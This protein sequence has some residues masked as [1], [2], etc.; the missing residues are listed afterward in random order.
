EE[1]VPPVYVKTWFHTGFFKNRT[2]ISKQFA[3][4]YFNGDSQAWLLPDTILPEGL[5]AIEAREACRALRG[6]ALRK[7][8]YAQDGTA[9]ESIPYTIEEK[10]FD[11][12]MLQGIKTNKHGV[13]HITERETLAYQYERDTTD[14]RIMQSLVLETDRYGNVTK[15]AQ[16]AYPRR[17]TPTSTNLP[18]QE[19]LHIL[20]TENRFINKTETGEIHLIGAGC[21]TKAY[22]ITGIPFINHKFEKEAL[23]TAVTDPDLI[24][25]IAYTATPGTTP[26]K[27]KIQH[28]R[29]YYWDEALTQHLLLGNIAPHALPY[30]KQ[31]LEITQDIL[32]IVN[33][34]GT[35]ITT[36]MLQNEGKYLQEGTNWWTISEIQTF[37]ATAFYQPVSVTD[38]FGG[39]TQLSYDSHKLLIESVTDADN[40]TTTVENNYRLLQAWKIIDPNGNSQCVDFDTLGMVKAMVVMGKN[41]E[42]DT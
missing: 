3:E 14:P 38:P 27:R 24:T 29:V 16:V 42:G 2:E 30:Q 17:T 40:R 18:E 37:D 26:E 8:V 20:Y 31:S 9:Q 22:E 10:N 7:E 12:R 5:T 21:E 19:K 36:T 4:E 15:S 25:E 34:D 11:I 41:G 6:S 39:T 32:D 1:I 35:K 33:N 13:F 28:D 23:K